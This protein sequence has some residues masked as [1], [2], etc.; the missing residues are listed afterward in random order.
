MGPLLV[1]LD[2]PAIQIGLQLVDRAVDLLA[3][4]DAVEL[5]KQRAMKA[6]ADPIIRYVILGAFATRCP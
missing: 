3:E 2:Q 5:V 1:V 4:R 6:L